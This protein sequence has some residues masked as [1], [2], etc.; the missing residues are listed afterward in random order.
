[1]GQREAPKRENRTNC[2]G[3]STVNAWVGPVA[4]VGHGMMFIE[5]ILF[6]NFMKHEYYVHALLLN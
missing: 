6:K 2:E 5:L 3:A 4:V 1:M